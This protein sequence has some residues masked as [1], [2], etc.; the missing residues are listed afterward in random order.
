MRLLMK[1]LCYGKESKPTYR[2]NEPILAA[3][4]KLW[5]IFRSS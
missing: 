4:T 5:V 3:N 2:I 1:F